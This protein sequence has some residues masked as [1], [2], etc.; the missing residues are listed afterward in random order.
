[1]GSKKK[2]NVHFRREENPDGNM[3]QH[4]YL[5]NQ[6]DFLT[7]QVFPLAISYKFENGPFFAHITIVPNKNQLILFT[8]A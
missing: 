2:G 8:Y 7:V 5:R 4:A 6:L 3:Q 1:M